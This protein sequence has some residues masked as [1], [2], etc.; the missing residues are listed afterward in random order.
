MAR[1]ILSGASRSWTNVISHGPRTLRDHLL[2]LGRQRRHSAPHPALALFVVRENYWEERWGKGVGPKSLVC[3]EGR[4]R[5]AF[6]SALGLDSAS[7][8]K[9]ATGALVRWPCPRTDIYL[10]I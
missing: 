1:L 9:G 4:R 6:W 3:P 7:R 10:P 5:E 8:L 2:H